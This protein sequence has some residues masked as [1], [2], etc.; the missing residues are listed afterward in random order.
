MQATNEQRGRPTGGPSRKESSAEGTKVNSS[1]RV[2]VCVTPF[3]MSESDPPTT[4]RA[5]PTRTIARESSSCLDGLLRSIE[6]VG[7]HHG[8]QAHSLRSSLR[9]ELDRFTLWTSNS[10]VFASVNASLDFRLLD[11]PDVVGLFL[12]QLEAIGWRLDHRKSLPRPSKPD[13]H[14]L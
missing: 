9:N 6:A 7:R 11:L 4:D 12:D 1:H 3:G 10:G 14:D 13:L 5:V 8:A 2:E